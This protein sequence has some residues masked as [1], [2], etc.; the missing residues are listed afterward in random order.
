MK[1]SKNKIKLVLG[2]DLGTSWHGWSLCQIDDQDENKNKIIRRGSHYFG[3]LS[4]MSGVYRLG[5]RGDFRRTRRVISRRKQRKLD[6][7]NLISKKYQHIF[8]FD[9][10]QVKINPTYN[11]YHLAVKGLKEEIKSDELFKV[12]YSKLAFRGSQYNLNNYTNKSISELLLES[13]E[14]NNKIRGNGGRLTD[15]YNVEYNKKTGEKEISKNEEKQTLIFSRKELRKDIVRILNNCKYLDCDFKNEYL[16]IFDRQRNFAYGPGSRN[17]PTNWGIYK[18]DGSEPKENLWEDLLRKC[19]VYNDQR[20]AFKG[21]VSGSIANLVSQLSFIRINNEFLK[22][23]QK[24]LIWN[25]ILKCHTKPTINN[26]RKI[27][28]LNS[29]D[30]FSH[31]P[32]SEKNGNEKLETLE[33]FRKLLSED[34]IY[35]KNLEEL[36][37]S[38]KLLKFD[39]ILE[40]MINKYL[41][42]SKEDECIAELNFNINSEECIRESIEL[43]GIAQLYD[44]KVINNYS[45]FSDFRKFRDFK[46]NRW[47]FSVRAL[48]DFNEENWLGKRTLSNFYRSQVMD[49]NNAEYVLYDKYDYKKER[50]YINEKLFSNKTFLSPDIKNASIEAIRLINDKLKWCR[51][52]NYYLSDI[53]ME[54]TENDQ[55]SFVSKEKKKEISAE[56]QKIF[57]L[58][59]EL[60]KLTNDN[61]IIENLKVLILS[62]GFNGKNFINQDYVDLYDGSNISLNDVIN[63]SG[64]YEMDHVLPK[65]RSANNKYENKVLVKLDNNKAKGKKTSYEF[66]GNNQKILQLWEDKIKK[67]NYKLYK[68]LIMESIPKGFLDSQLNNVSNIMRQIKD[69]LTCW[70]QEQTKNNK[71]FDNIC[72]WSVSGYT[73]QTIRKMSGLPEKHRLENEHHSIDASICALLG[74]IEKFKE[75]KPIYDLEKNYFIYKTHTDIF[76]NENIKLYQNITSNIHACNWEL[77]SKKLTKMWDEP[78]EEKLKY[79]IGTAADKKYIFTGPIGGQLI[80]SWINIDSGRKKVNKYKLFKSKKELSE[81][82]NLF[83][84]T[85]EE[86][87]CLNDK[88]VFNRL[89]Q[90]WNDNNDDSINNPFEI[91]L[92]KEIKINNEWAKYKKTMQVPFLNEKGK[93]III[94]S[95]KFIGK[96]ASV[97][98]DYNNLLKN[99]PKYKKNSYKSN[100]DTK[101]IYVIQNNIK[102]NSKIFFA[103]ETTNNFFYVTN[104]DKIESGIIKIVDIIEMGQLYID[105]NKNIFRVSTID[106]ES[107]RMHLVNI[108]NNELIRKSYPE[109]LKLNLEKYLNIF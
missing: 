92:N 72:I 99:H 14:Q 21:C 20:V 78:I 43:D 17:S 86:S 59:K 67:N 32:R 60:K 94:G 29:N 61:T 6:F 100:L 68:N 109:F 46:D 44:E 75:M 31:Y 89:K 4:N 103:K 10:Q 90:I 64:N 30:I 97:G 42:T 80:Y 102:N 45:K 28:C 35:I 77:T 9:I 7:I 12:L 16:S 96:N 88:P 27:L 56:N 82:A 2:L 11:I 63:N 15:S 76:N 70:S 95:L 62:H 5:E 53:V 85:W 1:N 26:F 54:T 108:N 50:Q 23:E 81:L 104:K 79:V 41:I 74:S 37:K 25:A 69:G 13:W 105:I 101:C 83:K 49:S 22:K 52:N 106:I 19:P 57:N 107:A 71:F 84:K 65:A 98:L 55:F 34:V 58:M 18:C 36:F 33:I 38:K 48:F 24:K 8:N 73:T 39:I 66:V 47:S 3:S 91:Y 40:Q 93:L 51:N 87:K